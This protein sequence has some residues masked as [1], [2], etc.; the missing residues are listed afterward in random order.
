[1]VLSLEK[2]GKKQEAAKLLGEMENFAQ[3][4]LDARPC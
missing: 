1:M 3:S 2:L 4:R